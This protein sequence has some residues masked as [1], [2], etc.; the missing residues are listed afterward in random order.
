MSKN[1]TKGMKRQAGIY[2][3]EHA[4]QQNHRC[5]YC[6]CKMIKFK[7]TD[8]F[9]AKNGRTAD[10]IIP[11]SSFGLNVFYNILAVCYDCN[12]KKD[13]NFLTLKQMLNVVRVKK[14]MTVRIVYELLKINYNRRSSKCAI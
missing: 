9:Q 5:A 14:L 2:R 11:L 1:R 13:S 4:K 7:R 3:D 10:H 6:R 8:S 12:Q